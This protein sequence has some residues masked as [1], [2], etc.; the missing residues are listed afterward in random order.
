MK[1]RFTALSFRAA[2]LV[3]VSVAGTAF[4]QNANDTLPAHPRFARLT[5]HLRSDLATP[6]HC[7]DH[8]EW[9]IRIRRPYL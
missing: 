8:V 1:Q 5:P 7:A 2:L 3:T 9:I 4:S 6:A